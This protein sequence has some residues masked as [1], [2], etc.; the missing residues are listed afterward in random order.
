MPYI[1]CFSDPG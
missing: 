1:V